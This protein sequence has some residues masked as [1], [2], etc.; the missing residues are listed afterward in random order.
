MVL[1]LGIGSTTKHVVGSIGDLLRQGKL[2]DNIRIPTSTKI[3][4]H[5]LSLE[6]PLLDLDA[7][8]FVNLATNGLDEVNPSLN[9]VKGYGGCLFREKM[10]ENKS[11]TFNFFDG[12][13]SKNYKTYKIHLQVVDK[14]E[15]GAVTIWTMEYE[16]QNE[17]IAP[18]YP[19]LDIVTAATK[20]ID[21]H[22]VLKA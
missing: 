18:P 20:S 2:K 16:K 15:G 10:V 13:I 8:P 3:H 17:D 6:I 19:Y 7:H 22:H 4:D 5:S 9:L 1:D 11:I 21:A 14:E 12:E